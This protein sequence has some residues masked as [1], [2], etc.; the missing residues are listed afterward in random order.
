MVIAESAGVVMQSEAGVMA[1][2]EAAVTAVNGIVWGPAM[3]IL[4]LGTGLYLMV[5]LGFMPLRRLPAAFRL[6]FQGR[7]AGTDE[8]GE[9]TPF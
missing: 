4:I 7:R 2:I 8:K 3:L 6:M 5:G 9:I 1:Q